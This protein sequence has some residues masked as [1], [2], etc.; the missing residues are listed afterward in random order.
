M[1]NLTP[2]EIFNNLLYVSLGALTGILTLSLTLTFV[3]RSELN[4]I[5]DYLTTR[6]Q[7]PE[8]Y[9][10]LLIILLTPAVVVILFRTIF[11]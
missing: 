9:I 5:L 10:Y 3:P 8:Q 6:S 11:G 1:P 7:S 4:S 2:T